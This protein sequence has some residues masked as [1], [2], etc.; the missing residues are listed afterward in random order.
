MVIPSVRVGSTEQR[1]LVPLHS[2]VA[3]KMG[4]SQLMHKEES[5]NECWFSKI[6]HTVLSWCKC[7]VAPRTSPKNLAYRVLTLENAQ[8]SA[9]FYAIL[10]ARRAPM[11]CYNRTAIHV[12][13]WHCYKTSPSCLYNL[14]NSEQ[15][16]LCDVGRIQP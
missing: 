5:G 10:C 13:I 9:K 6:W 2:G 16:F 12:P 3:F 7:T 1:G 14:Y 4:L 11:E 15:G 8:A